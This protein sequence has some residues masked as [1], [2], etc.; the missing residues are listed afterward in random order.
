MSVILIIRSATGKAAA[1]P[2]ISINLDYFSGAPLDQDFLNTTTTISAK[3]PLSASWVSTFKL[4]HVSD[5]I[6]QNQID[7][8]DTA[9]RKDFAHTSRYSLDWQND[10]QWNPQNLLTAGL[11]RDQED[12]TA[13]S[14][15]T[16]FDTSS[17]T[18]AVYAQNVRTTA[19]TTLITGVR[20]TNNQ[21]YG[22]H[23]TWNLEY[24]LNL[25]DSLRLTLA[26]NSGFRAPDSND[27]YAA[28]G[29]PNLKPEKSVNNEI[30]LRYKIS[31]AQRIH[32]NVFKNRITNLI[33]SDSSYV[34]QNIGQATITG[35]ELV[36]E[37]LGQRWSASAS[38]S[39]QDPHDDVNNSQLLRRSKHTYSAMIG[40]RG[41]AFDIGVEAFHS[42]NR[43]DYGAILDPYTLVNLHGDYRFSQ[44][45]S[46]NLRIENLTDEDYQLAYGYNTPG[47]SAYAE[48][49]YSM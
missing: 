37:F 22:D 1:I 23:T 14:Y 33:V 41:N 28:G 6:D 18:N 24:G 46:L 16:A 40:Y 5:K 17:Y 36:Y 19:K 48:L 10:L 20:Y 44:R 27:L 7:P 32:L 34:L 45:L 8:Y 43:P 2:N 38:A 39:V 26:N 9:N 49:R 47:R 35:S 12:T 4:S 13:L 31:N 25:T 21:I 3:T 15:G 11:Y 42:G 29:N 30:G